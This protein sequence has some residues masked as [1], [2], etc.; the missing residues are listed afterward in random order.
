MNQESQSS[1][2]LLTVLRN[3][4]IEGE[5]LEFQAGTVLCHQGVPV[6]GV[7]L[8]KSGVVHTFMTVGKKQSPRIEEIVSGQFIG[9]TAVLSCGNSDVSAVAVTNV[10]AVLIR[11][12]ELLSALQRT[13]ELYMHINECL[14]HAV[15]A[16]YGHVRDIR[17]TT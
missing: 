10:H 1:E 7:L 8:I 2:T 3:G 16:A 5:D 12:E 14:S 17:S 15:S 13:P 6:S 9:L 4:G 11:S